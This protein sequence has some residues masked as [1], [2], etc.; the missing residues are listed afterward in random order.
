MTHTSHTQIILVHPNLI[1]LTHQLFQPQLF[2]SR[3]RMVPR[4]FMPSS[5]PLGFTPD[6]HRALFILYLGWFLSLGQQPPRLIAQL[7]Q[8]NLSPTDLFI[9][10]ST[11]YAPPTLFRHL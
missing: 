10:D 4:I 6:H 1:R 3:D 11:S 9:R 8:P 7:F 5:P 2:P